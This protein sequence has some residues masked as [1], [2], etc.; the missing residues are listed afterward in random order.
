MDETDKYFR[1]ISRSGPGTDALAALPEEKRKRMAEKR[2]R[3]VV[4]A[5]RIQHDV[6]WSLHDDP[7]GVFDLFH[8]RTI[9]SEL[10]G[11]MWQAV[12]TDEG[13]ASISEGRLPKR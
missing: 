2:Q 7:V 11:A 12:K 6:D 10:V 5:K 8:Y 4:V 3:Y 13:R 1:K 9:A